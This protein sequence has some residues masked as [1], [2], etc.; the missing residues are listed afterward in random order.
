MKAPG[1]LYFSF[2][3]SSIPSCN[4]QQVRAFL[5]A[6]KITRPKQAR[7]QN[8]YLHAIEGQPNITMW[9][10]AGANYRWN[11]SWVTDGPYNLF[12]S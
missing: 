10:L 3:I 6:K 8:H 4:G 7:I 11:K 9:T 1:I 12:Q 2:L 5:H